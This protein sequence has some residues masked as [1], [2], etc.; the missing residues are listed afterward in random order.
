MR[1]GGVT[2]RECARRVFRS[3]PSGMGP[4]LDGSRFEFWKPIDKEDPALWQLGLAP[5]E[6][7]AVASP[8][9][10]PCAAEEGWGFAPAAPFSPNRTEGCDARG[11]LGGC[12]CSLGFH[13]RHCLAGHLQRTPR[14]D[15]AGCTSLRLLARIYG[16]ETPHH[17]WQDNTGVM[18]EVIA[19]T[20]V[21]QGCPASMAAFIIGLRAVQERVHAR[22]DPLFAATAGSSPALE[23]TPL[24]SHADDSY[25]AAPAQLVQSVLDVWSDG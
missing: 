19:S 4:G 21:E 7:D 6:V 23:V 25:T 15:A 18:H 13:W 10:P 16:A 20:G 2:I 5:R 3:L 17:W 9:P 22:L 14:L 24:G 11:D 8:W 12:N 1:S